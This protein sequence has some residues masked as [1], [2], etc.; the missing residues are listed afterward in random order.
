MDELISEVILKL[1]LTFPLAIL[2]GIGAGKTIQTIN[3]LNMETRINEIAIDVLKGQIVEKLE[4]LLRVYSDTNLD[5]NLPATVDLQGVCERVIFSVDSM[6]WL[7]YIYISMVDHGTES[8]PFIQVL[9]F[10]SLS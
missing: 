4:I 3:S 7:N 2:V 8:E 9:H 5:V 6:N 10:L 1:S